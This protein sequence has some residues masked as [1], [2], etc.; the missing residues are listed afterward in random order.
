MRLSALN[1]SR[2]LGSLLIMATFALSA[3]GCGDSVETTAAPA[4]QASPQEQVLTPQDK[5]ARYVK[6]RFGRED[7]YPLITSLALTSGYLG[8][9]TA[10]R[11]HST[12]ERNR[13]RAQAMCKP[14]LTS[15]GVKAVYV[16]YDSRGGGSSVSCGS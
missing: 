12:P 16:Y 8:V 15:P 2:L 3:S 6:R 7:W 11:D 10:L 13:K 9:S 4:E 5:V 14:L 1:V